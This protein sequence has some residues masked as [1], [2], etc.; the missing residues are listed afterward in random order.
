MTTTLPETMRAAV[1]DGPRAMSVQDLA[2]P[3]P[4]P[5]QAV[6]A[7][8]HC[9]ICGS[10]LHLVVEGWG[11][12]GTVYG[13]EW[14]GRVVAIG[15]DVTG[16]SPGDRVVG[17]PVACG[18]CRWCRS[19]R[20]A[21]CAEDPL[22]TGTVHA[23]AYAQFQVVPV[24][25]LHRIPDHLDERTAALSEPLAVALHA[26]GNA[27]LPAPDARVLVTGAGP[28]G[29]LVTAA[30]AAVGVT[31]LTVSEPVAARRDRALTVGATSVLEPSQLPEP[32]AMPTECLP[33]GWDVVLDCSGR[34]A[35][36]EPALGLLVQGGR[37]VLVGTG[38]FDARIDPTRMMIN[39]LV[40]T[41]AYCYDA[42]QIDEALDLLASG[43]LPVD[44]LVEPDD[45]P[46]DRLLDAME[47]CAAGELPGKVLVRP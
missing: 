13:H 20:P 17:G 8:D 3:Q 44:A 6:V 18:R 12:P 10:D 34:T 43:R 40:V 42:G 37:L 32:P 1:Y 4:G 38:S 28:I 22:R 27:G 21:L 46:L 24:A 16:W 25:A 2:V 19:G 47:R 29:L 23:G 35:A 14:S 45:V 41:G 33:G 39:E 36:I 15:A 5:G 9:G 30:A 26:L 7:V 31:D 11:V